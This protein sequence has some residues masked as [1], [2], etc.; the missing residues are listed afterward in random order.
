MSIFNNK[1]VWIGLSVIMQTVV[2]ILFVFLAAK[3]IRPGKT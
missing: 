2:G 3:H 1:Y